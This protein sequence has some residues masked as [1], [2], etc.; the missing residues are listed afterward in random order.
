MAA[1][2]RLDREYLYYEDGPCRLC[3]PVEWT[4]AKT[5]DHPIDLEIR[6]G[7][8]DCWT[9]PAGARID[10]DRRE[11]IL[12]EIGSYYATGPAADV[13]GENGAL[14]RGPSKYRFYL[15]IPPTP[16]RY[17]EQGLYLSIPMAQPFKGAKERR[18]R[19]ILDFTGIREWTSPRIPID[20]QHLRMIARRIVDKEQI[21]AIGIEGLP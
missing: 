10:R 7:A 5:V 14:L 2:I 3:L 19:F 15:Q 21:G 13:L 16:S 17:Y 6:A 20:S 4:Y 9:E 12:D 18:H 1:Q 11:S 8:L